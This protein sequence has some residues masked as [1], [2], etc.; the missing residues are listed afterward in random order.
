[1]QVKVAQQEGTITV[2]VAG[3]EPRNYNVKDGAVTVA[4]D[5]VPAFLEAVAGSSVSQADAKKLD[6]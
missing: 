5:D 3:G 1:M 2:A 4:A 6:A